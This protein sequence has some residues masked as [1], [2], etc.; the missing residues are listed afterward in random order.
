MEQTYFVDKN[1]LLVIKRK[2]EW[3]S[4]QGYFSLDSENRLVYWLNEPASWRTKYQLPDKIVF[5]G[6]WKINSNYDLELELEQK[7]QA[8]RKER[9]TLKGKILSCQKEHIAFEIQTINH[10]GSDS[11][12]LLKL[13]GRWQADEYNRITFLITKKGQPDTLTF[14]GSWQLNENQQITYVYEKTDLKTKSKVLHSLVLSGY[15]QITSV[16][17]LAYILSSGANSRFGFKVQIESPNIRP[18]EGSIKYRLGIGIRQPKREKAKI[19]TLYG[20]WRFSRYAGFI[21]E[22]SHRDGKIYRLEFGAEVSFDRNNQVT[23]KLTSKNREPL[24]LSLTFTHK[25]LK[26]LDGGGELFL[27]LKRYREESGVDVGIRI[28]W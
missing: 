18:K 19:I 27:R 2:K 25:L 21:F 24:G 22:M 20:T 9:L 10:D 7:E 12:Y 3:L 1:N 6:L 5:S 23:F 15:W 13:S 4:P 11:F 16:D 26:E 14:Q 28:P 17:R 8:F